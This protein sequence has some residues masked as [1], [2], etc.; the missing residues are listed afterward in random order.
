MTMVKAK[1]LLSIVQRDQ[2]AWPLQAGSD[3]KIRQ[4]ARGYLGSDSCKQETV[5]KASS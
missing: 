5:P 4:K 2:F 1:S 3:S